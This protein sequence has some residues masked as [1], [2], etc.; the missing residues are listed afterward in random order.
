MSD[1]QLGAFKKRSWRHHELLEVFP[2]ASIRIMDLGSGASPFRG[3]SIDIVE[4]V[5][6]A[7]AADHHVDV[8]KEWPFDEGSFDM[9]YASH[10]IEHFYAHDRDNVVRNVWRALKPGGIFFFRVP[11]KSSIQATGWEHYT[12]YGLNAAVSLCH[13]GNPA[14]PRFEAITF[15]AACIDVSGFYR[16]RRPSFEP[17]LNLSHNLSEKLLSRLMYGGIPEV[18]F[19]LRRPAATLPG[20]AT[21]SQRMAA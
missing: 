19:L 16:K 21:Q 17:L 7:V 10:V 18:Q 12:L 4:C 2:S 14:L 20:S 6:F 15:G 8:V 9:V 13:G 5:D 1:F 3:R 11:H